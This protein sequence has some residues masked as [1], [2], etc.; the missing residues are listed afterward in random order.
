MRVNRERGGVLAGIMLVVL[1]LAVLAVAAIVSTGLYIAHNVRVTEKSARGETTVETPFGT[2][3]VRESS[4]FDPRNL[5]LPVYPGAVRDYDSQK[6]ATLDLDFGETHKGFGILAAAY[7]TSDPI[8][9]VTGYYRA[10]LPH[11]M[12]SEK[13][14][15]GFQL[16]MT[17][18]GYK[19]IVVIHEDGGETRIGLASVGEP[20]SN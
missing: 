19:K 20:A 10:E 13:T 2:L 9:K 8:G 3:R 18:R 5:G 4:H 17:E 16:E 7:R 11:W 1:V 14:Q 12:F 15:G 6:I